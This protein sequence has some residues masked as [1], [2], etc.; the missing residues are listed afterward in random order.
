MVFFVFLGKA[1]MRIQTKRL[2]GLL[3]L[4]AALTVGV[5]AASVDLRL[6]DAAA[7]RDTALVRALLDE[8]SMLTPRVPTV[9]RRCSGSRT[10]TTPKRSSCSCGPAPT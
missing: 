1:T 4:P 6:V 7:A 3:L 2:A 5:A 10:G 8:G 9:R